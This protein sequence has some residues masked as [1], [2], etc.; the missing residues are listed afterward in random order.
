MSSQP[1]RHRGQKRKFP[2]TKSSGWQPRRQLFEPA[3]NQYGRG[4]G[5]GKGKAEGKGHKGKGKG[6]Y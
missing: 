3:G 5:Q 4:R 6:K 1:A 2:D